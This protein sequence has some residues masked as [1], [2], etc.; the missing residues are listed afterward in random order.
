MAGDRSSAGYSC[1]DC[2]G[3]LPVYGNGLPWS[4]YRRWQLQHL[5]GSKRRV[6]YR[7]VTVRREGADVTAPITI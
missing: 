4:Y 6:R 5:I 1:D 3:R 7:S 2:G